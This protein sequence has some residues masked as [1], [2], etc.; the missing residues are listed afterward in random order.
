VLIFKC[1]ARRNFCG[2]PACVK[3]LPR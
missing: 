1:V 3:P 2:P